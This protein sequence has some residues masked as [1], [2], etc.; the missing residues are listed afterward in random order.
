MTGTSTM[1]AIN[2]SGSVTLSGT[3]FFRSPTTSNTP[4]T[5]NFYLAASG[6]REGTAGDFNI[7]TYSGGWGARLTVSQ[8]GAV[9]IPGTLG[10]TGVIT[11]TNNDLILT[12]AGQFKVASTATATGTAVVHNANGYYYDLTSSR[13]FKENFRAIP[14]DRAALDR[15]LKLTP[16]L[17]D[18]KD[19]IDK[20]VIN[21]IAE[22]SA[23]AEKDGLLSLTNYNGDGEAQSL[24]DYGFSAY[25]QLVLQDHEARLAA[26]QEEFQSY[27]NSHP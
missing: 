6:I 3:S 8:A 23:D 13:R 7:D 20:D 12:S 5:F 10:V 22:D 9:S 14:N 19:G 17:F 25:Q 27:K 24:R 18:V 2:A 15:F 21:F 11:V 4:G 16:E 26:L 1:A